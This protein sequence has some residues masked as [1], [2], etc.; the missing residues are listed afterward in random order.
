MMG[1]LD[2]RVCVVTGAGRGLGREHALLLAAEGARVVVNDLGGA[3]DGSGEDSG[4]A[5]EVVDEI[6]AAGG[7]AIANT[8]SVTSWAGAQQLVLD[9]IN[10]Y[11][12]LDVLVNNAGI[13][14]DRSL[15]NLEEAEWDA[16]IA[17]HL[18]GHVAPTRWA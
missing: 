16:V 8:D 14:R 18:K 15:V 3:I 17:V 6:R 12:R 4:P 2:G 13:L 9:A 10:A 5:H 7:E 11:G 1:L